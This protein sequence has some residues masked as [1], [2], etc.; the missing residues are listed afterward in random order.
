MYAPRASSRG[1]FARSA[2]RRSATATPVWTGMPS[3]S[4]KSSYAPRPQNEGRCCSL[5]V[6]GMASLIFVPL[7]SRDDIAHSL[8]RPSYR[9]EIIGAPRRRRVLQEFA[10]TIHL[11]A[12]HD[13]MWDAVNDVLRV[14][15]WLPI[16]REVRRSEE[17][18]SEL[19]SP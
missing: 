14:A 11:A 12:T 19:Q 7:A 6:A 16:V 9:D 5:L 4:R 15:S 3:F 2:V 13:A 8:A 10:K 1:H 18:T 17:H